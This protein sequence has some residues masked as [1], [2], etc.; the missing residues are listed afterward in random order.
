VVWEPGD[1]IVL[2]EVWRDRLWAV[3]PLTVVSDTDGELVLWCPK[4]T[5]R[6]V[7]W[8]L[9]DLPTRLER[10]VHCLNTGEW[11]L[12]DSVWDVSTLWVIREGD[13]HAT[14]VS[15]LEDGSHWGWYV[16]LQEPYVR[17]PRGISAMDQMLDVV[18]DPDRTWRW[19]D[20]DELD[21]AVALGL[22]DEDRVALL[23]AEA[24]SVVADMEAER[25]PF[26]DPW[27]SWV[28][29]PWPG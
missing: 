12:V 25:A 13:W 23:R 16:N 14:W 10:V 8:P 3:R 17:T 22:F 21:A 29:P 1:T 27:I 19:K 20:E 7:P 24:L 11:E 26:C 5:V 6:Q 18:V 4:G 28:P 9:V 15:F 2:E